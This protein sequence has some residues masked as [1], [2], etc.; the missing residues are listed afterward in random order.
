MVQYAE[1][2]CLGYTIFSPQETLGMNWQTRL[3]YESDEM[4]Q[5]CQEE[6]FLQSTCMDIIT[7]SSYLGHD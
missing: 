5:A 3:V 2:N 1:Q 7:S 6:E 4:Y